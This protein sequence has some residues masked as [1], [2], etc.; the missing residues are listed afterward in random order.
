MKRI[1]IVLSLLISSQIALCQESP[2]SIK[3]FLTVE[4]FFYA[5]YN[6]VRLDRIYR[7]LMDTLCKTGFS[8]ISIKVDKDG[9]VSDVT[10][11]NNTPSTLKNIFTRI[12]R[13]SNGQW[14][15][16]KS[17]EGQSVTLVIPV[18][19][20]FFTQGKCVEYNNDVLPSLQAMM[21]V[22]GN[23]KKGKIDN[24]ERTKIPQKNW[25][26]SPM[27]IQSPFY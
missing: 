18:Y 25:L 2:I 21:S 8:F 20:R 19:Y 24:I 5:K 13:D 16:N 14:V 23:T 15:V 27:F 4:D 7:N 22:F 9:A 12:G 17:V 6:E 11:D 10:V 26:F 3:G 1:L